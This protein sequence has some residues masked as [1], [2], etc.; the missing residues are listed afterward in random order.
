M[1][2]NVRNLDT[3]RAPNTAVATAAMRRNA[4]TVQA[5]LTVLNW[6]LR[7]TFTSQSGKGSS[8]PE[9]CKIATVENKNT[10]NVPSR[11]AAACCDGF[12]EQLYPPLP[13]ATCFVIF[14]TETIS[15]R[16][17]ILLAI[18]VS[19]GPSQKWTLDRL[20]DRKRKSRFSSIFYLFRLQIPHFPFSS[21]F[22]RRFASGSKIDTNL[23]HCCIKRRRRGLYV[24]TLAPGDQF[25]SVGVYTVIMGLT[26]TADVM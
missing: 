26:A 20:I 17:T 23:H 13:A 12:Q 14:Q 15:D 18:I 4:P 21:Y 1:H 11:T 24:R 2:R 7:R 6:H 19:D 16:P 3:V 10:S 25:S 5:A 22:S 9:A 8:F